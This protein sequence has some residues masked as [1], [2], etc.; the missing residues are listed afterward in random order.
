MKHNI[1]LIHIL[2]FLF[3]TIQSE[4]IFNTPFNNQG[5]PNDFDIFGWT[6]DGTG[7][8]GYSNNMPNDW[9]TD[10]C[11]VMSKQ[12]QSY[13]FVSTSG[14][15]YCEPTTS[16]PSTSEPSTSEPSTSEPTTSEPT[17]SEPTTSEPTTSGT[18][19]PS[20]SEPSTS[21][22]STSEPSTSEPS[23]S[24]PTTSDP[25]TSDPTSSPPTRKTTMSNI[26]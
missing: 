17:T 4:V 22:P 23:T 12:G 1:T 6:Y 16:E 9:G 26:D 21:E 14:Y 13:N 5:N 19:E 24:E 7:L 18:S 2:I 15:N 3:T 8:Y 20:T 10:R 11:L 25:T